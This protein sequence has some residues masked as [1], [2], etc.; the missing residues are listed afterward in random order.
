MERLLAGRVAQ[1]RVSMLLLGLFGVLGLIIA[2]IGLYGVMSYFVTQ[3]T[4]EIGVR[5]ALGATRV[6]ILAMVLRNAAMLLSVGLAIGAVASWYASAAARAFLFRLQPADP[7]AFAA[8][9]TLLSIAAVIAAV[10]PAR[11]AASV[12]PLVALRSE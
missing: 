11:R 7:R 2:A 10:L 1:R 6:G 8:A 4:R 12:D 9:A 3:R 5:M